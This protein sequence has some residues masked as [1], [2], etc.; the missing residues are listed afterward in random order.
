[1]DDDQQSMH[2]QNVKSKKNNGISDF[3]AKKADLISLKT[4]QRML[5][6]PYW[7]DCACLTK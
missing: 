5:F 2:Q 3:G 6:N 7:K 4:I 1:M